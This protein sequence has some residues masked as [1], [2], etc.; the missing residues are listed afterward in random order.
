MRPATLDGSLGG[1]GLVSLYGT[2]VVNLDI[3]GQDAAVDATTA[4]RDIHSTLTYTTNKNTA[5]S[6][7]AI[8][9]TLANKSKSARRFALPVTKHP[10]ATNRRV[11]PWGTR[12]AN[13][14]TRD[15]R[16]SLKIAM[17]ITQHAN[18][19]THYTNCVLYTFSSVPYTSLSTFHLCIPSSRPSPPPN[20]LLP[21]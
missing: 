20:S 21:G 6:T 15:P 14:Q 16:F 5:E 11:Q 17:P 19:G 13:R 10:I 2:L 8:T 9:T 12:S 18:T 3:L 7:T 1:Y 4:N